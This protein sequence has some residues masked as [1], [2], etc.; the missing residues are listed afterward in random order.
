MVAEPLMPIPQLSRIAGM[1]NN[2][3]VRHLFKCLTANAYLSHCII[4]II[5]LDIGKLI[6]KS[7]DCLWDT[8][9]SYKNGTTRKRV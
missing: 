4:R 5:I 9:R 3:T 6:E 8:T 2:H 1:H 7:I